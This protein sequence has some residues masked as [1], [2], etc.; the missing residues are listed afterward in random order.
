MEK[1]KSAEVDEALPG[2]DDGVVATQKCGT[3]FIEARIRDEAEEEMDIE[4]VHY[5]NLAYSS[6][7]LLLTKDPRTSRRTIIQP[8]SSLQALYG[9]ISGRV[10]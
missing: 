1:E 9:S 10:Q 7:N 3:L 8:E 5:L 4:K 2:G 6:T